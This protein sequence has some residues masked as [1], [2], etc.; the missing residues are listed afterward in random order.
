ML[1]EMFTAMASSGSLMSV[2]ATSL[3]LPQGMGVAT[4]QSLRKA[5]MITKKGRGSSAADMLPEDAATI[6]TALVSGATVAQ[7]AQVT[8]LLLGMPHVLSFKQGTIAKGFNSVRTPPSPF[9][10]TSN[11][12]TLHKGL[13]AVLKASWHQD[14]EF[15]E[16]GD[17]WYPGYNTL[18]DLD[19]LSFTLG[20]DG[21]RSGGFALI[22]ARVTKEVVMTRFYSTWPLRSRIGAALAEGDAQKRSDLLADVAYDPWLVFESQAKLMNASR[23]EGAV[24]Q[25][26]L[27]CLKDEAPK[28]RQ[29]VKRFAQY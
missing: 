6:L 1:E 26:A 13:T 18:L 27:D 9:Y 12:S 17:V 11:T 4:L 8:T 20:M 19:S 2:I 7:V 23:V 5:D 29:R 24:F 14:A 15:D 28:S 10:G 25:E 22:R 16:H 3:G 21:G